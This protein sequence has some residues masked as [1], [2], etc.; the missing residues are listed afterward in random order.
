[1]I[2]T[3]AVPKALSLLAVLFCQIC[4][5]VGEVV[6]EELGQCLAWEEGAPDTLHF[7]H[8]LQHRVAARSGKTRAE[9]TCLLDN[10][11]C[12]RFGAEG[13]PSERLGTCCSRACT[14]P[15]RTR[16]TDKF[17]AACTDVYDSE[18]A[19]Y[20][21]FGND[22]QPCCTLK[23]E[24]RVT[25]TGVRYACLCSNKGEPCLNARHCCDAKSSICNFPADGGAGLCL[26]IKK[27]VTSEVAR[28]QSSQM[29]PATRRADRGTFGLSTP[30][31]GRAAPTIQYVW[32]GWPNRALRQENN[33][34]FGT[35]AAGR[36]LT[37]ALAIELAKAMLE[38]ELNEIYQP[39]VDE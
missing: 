10:A 26:D 27:M 37:L 12:E 13:E 34:L 15:D 7:M 38:K 11:M 9:P 30:V 33:E 29:A 2:M 3:R 5:A 35:P 22:E 17:C 21:Q 8:F 18:F 6:S 1:M 36:Q 24:P 25:D 20:Q 39:L 19:E 23:Q 16:T 28:F 31:R 14:F 4:L 32:V